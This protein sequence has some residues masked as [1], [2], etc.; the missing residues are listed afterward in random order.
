MLFAN[1][2][3]TTENFEAMG[4]RIRQELRDHKSKYIFQAM[5]FILAGVLAAAFPAN[6]AVNVE[7][8]VG[9]VLL[10]TGVFQLVLTL[11]SKMHWWSLV[12][13]C[14]SIAIGLLMLWKP[15]PFLLAFVTL[16]AIFM[17]LEGV[18]EILLAFQFRHARNWS[19]MFFSGA[20]TLL[21]A[22]MLW[23]G[24]PALDVLYLGW[25]IAINL[26]FYGLSLLMLVWKSAA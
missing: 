20:V 6:T 21:I 2:S 22:V 9:A 13:S 25:M 5:I 18:L 23:I 1:T 16:L 24:F 15:L 11:K 7:L 3:S 19:W 8:I 26:I 14:L 12:S 4:A 17:T 10:F